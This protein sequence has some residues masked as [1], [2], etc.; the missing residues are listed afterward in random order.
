MLGTTTP[1][2]LLQ[3]RAP[4][5]L[6][7]HTLAPHTLA[8]HTLAHA[9]HTPRR[10]GHAEAAAPTALSVGGMRA[11]A[12]GGAAGRGSGAGQRGSGAAR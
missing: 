6:A 10:P 12:R 11:R 2:T 8:P 4:H 5:T 1:T 7:P 3:A 9:T